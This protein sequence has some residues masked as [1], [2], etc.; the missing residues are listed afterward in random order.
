MLRLS[1]LRLPLDHPAD[2]LPAAIARR[3]GIAADDLL[4]V[5]VFKRS[6][7]ARKSHSLSFIYIV[8]VETRNETALL[9]KF[10]DDL[11]VK[12]TPDMEYHFVGKAPAHVANRP[13]V[14]GLGP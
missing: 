13:L 7:D 8:D 3:L 12:P 10:A 1:E 5:N 6:Y 2:A 11:H 9:K 14:I 4:S